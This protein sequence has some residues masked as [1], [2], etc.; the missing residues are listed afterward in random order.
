MEKLIEKVLAQIKHD[1]MEG[2]FTAVE[3][4]L[5]ACPVLSLVGFCDE[6]IVVP[7]D[8]DDGEDFQEYEYIDSGKPV[9][10]GTPIGYEVLNTDGGGWELILLDNITFGS[11]AR[12]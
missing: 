7:V 1:V 2:D 9:P 5:K 8:A 4:L 10:S 3:E 11:E 12:D 6:N